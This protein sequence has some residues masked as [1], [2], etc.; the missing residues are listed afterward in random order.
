[1]RF[2]AKLMALLPATVLPWA[3]AQAAPLDLSTVE[4]AAQWL[5][6]Y[7]EAPNPKLVSRAMLVLSKEGVFQKDESAAPTFGFLAGVLAKNKSIAPSLIKDLTA[8]PEGEQKVLVLGIWYSGRPDTKKL[9]RGL[10][11]TMPQHKENIENLL[12]SEPLRLTQIPLEQGP[13][14]LD[15]LWGNFMA[16]GDAEPVKRVMEALPWVGVE[17]HLPQY[18]VGNAAR[19]SLASH[20]AQHRRVLALCREQ[21]KVQPP[22]VANVLKEVIASAEARRTDPAKP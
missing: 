20:A 1:L 5:T 19:W 6:H 3:A 8:L 9:L 16:T 4:S 18:A 21:V 12:H 7:Y 15:A 2:A 17:S 13:W 10:L 11:A 22:E 14:V